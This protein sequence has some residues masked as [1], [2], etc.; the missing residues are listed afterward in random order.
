MVGYTQVY[1]VKHGL[2]I[3]GAHYVGYVP[4]VSVVAYEP[5]KHGVVDSE[6]SFAARSWSD[7]WAVHNAV[8]GEGFR[9]SVEVVGQGYLWWS[10]ALEYI[11][12]LIV[13]FYY[14]GG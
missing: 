13:R 12:R 3:S 4:E 7:P 5:V 6:G 2:R 1:H 14:Y 8:E 11:F 9:C 10:G